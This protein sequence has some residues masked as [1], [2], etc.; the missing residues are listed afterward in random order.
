MTLYHLEPN[1]K[2]APGGLRDCNVANWLALLST[3][4]KSH[5]PSRA[6]ALALRANWKRW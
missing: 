6:D 4:L 5:V 2:E 3:I 1:L